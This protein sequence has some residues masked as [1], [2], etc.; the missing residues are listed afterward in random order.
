MVR[1]EERDSPEPGD[2]L[3]F[4]GACVAPGIWIPCEDAKAIWE[5]LYGLTGIAA[6]E[7]V[8]ALLFRKRLF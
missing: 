4:G 5:G 2:S 6:L 7:I 1:V 3:R 8:P